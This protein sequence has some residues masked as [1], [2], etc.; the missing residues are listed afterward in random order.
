MTIDQIASEVL[1]LAPYERALL[2]QTLWESLDNQSLSPADLS[3]D[4]EL[5]LAQ[6]RDNEMET[7]TVTP[8]SH[9]DLMTRLR[10]A[11]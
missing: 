3:D 4:A 7:G 9:T 1:N 5:A 10:R 8:V 6:Q 2:A 11:H